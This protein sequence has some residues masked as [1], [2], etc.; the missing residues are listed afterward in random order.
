[1]STTTH[2][3]GLNSH[4]LPSIPEIDHNELKKYLRHPAIG[5]GSDYLKILN[6]MKRRR[7]IIE[8]LLQNVNLEENE[9]LLQLFK[10]I[11]YIRS[12]MSKIHPVRWDPIGS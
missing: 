1:M 5:G 12:T 4:Q 9:R 7:D 8:S 3:L 10:Q 11:G 2:V 6:T